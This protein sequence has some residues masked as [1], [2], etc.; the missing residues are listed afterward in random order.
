MQPFCSDSE[1]GMASTSASPTVPLENRKRCLFNSR[2]GREEE[3][4]ALV[5]PT[6]TERHI[7]CWSLNLGVCNFL[8]L[9]SPLLPPT[10]TCPLYPSLFLP[11]VPFF[12]QCPPPPAPPP[13]PSRIHHGARTCIS[14]PMHVLAETS[15][16]GLKP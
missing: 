16:S 5:S 15:P 3:L 8:L 11:L 4:S 1:V 10:P 12:V 14:C 9:P 6:K 13:P 2:T 7:T